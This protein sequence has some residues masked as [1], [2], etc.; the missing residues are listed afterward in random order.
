MSRFDPFWGIVGLKEVAQARFR[1]A[2]HQSWWPTDADNKHLQR[3]A[4]AVHLPDK[5]NLNKIW[6]KQGEKW[7]AAFES[8]YFLQGWLCRTLDP[9]LLHWDREA[10]PPGEAPLPADTHWK[11]WWPRRAN[12]LELEIL[13][14]RDTTRTWILTRSSL[15]ETAEFLIRKPNLVF[16]YRMDFVICRWFKTTGFKTYRY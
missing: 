16:V 14:L 4:P 10:G 12:S 8:T 15:N 7:K 1:P 13:G 11:P 9:H 6:D 3:P 5:N 2:T